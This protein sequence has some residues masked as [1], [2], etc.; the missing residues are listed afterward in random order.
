MLA[1]TA[2]F[3]RIQLTG[4]GHLVKNLKD[5]SRIKPVEIEFNSFQWQPF[6]QYPDLVN[7]ERLLRME[8]D[9]LNAHLQ[10]PKCLL[11][12]LGRI[13]HIHI[14]PDQPGIRLAAHRPYK[15]EFKRIKLS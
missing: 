4:I 8:T 14:L 5:Q 1:G 15:L 3:R 9:R 13:G 12:G 6:K 7:S 10:Q 11:P 2:D